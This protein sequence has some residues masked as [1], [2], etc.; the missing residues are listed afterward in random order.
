MPKR[1]GDL[2]SASPFDYCGTPAGRADGLA[3]GRLAAELYER[4]CER[5]AGQQEKRHG[6]EK[7]LEKDILIPNMSIST[8]SETRFSS[9][10]EAR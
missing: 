7:G 2:D 1:S 3:P 4:S 10:A 9:A 8:A 6:H 5:S